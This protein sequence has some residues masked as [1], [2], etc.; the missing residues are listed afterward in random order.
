MY[1]RD[2]ENEPT[3]ETPE[4][5]DP[6]D[7][8]EAPSDA[9]EPAP[10]STP[11]PAAQEGAADEPADGADA[12]A[13]SAPG[14]NGP[15]LVEPEVLIEDPPTPE[16]ILQGK[17][18]EASARLRA[19]SK[20]Y[21][22]VQAEMKSFRERMENQARFKAERQ[23]FE[24]ARA[25]FDPVQN[26][27]RSLENAPE[28]SPVRDGLQMVLQQFMV[29]LEKLGMEEIPGVGASFDPKVHEALAITPVTDKD[30]DGTVLMVHADGYTVQ[31]KVLQAAQ[32]VVGKYQ[33][34]AGEA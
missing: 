24:Q 18:D 25:F 6:R 12:P 13:E 9:A 33:E 4:G 28:D 27:K 1:D 32:V 5:A 29:A 34:P 15:E 19:V 23:A 16:E 31:G 26:L 8:A 2:D 7:E 10:E 20:A 3:D 21:K 22:D 17:L 11:E 14:A 30:Q